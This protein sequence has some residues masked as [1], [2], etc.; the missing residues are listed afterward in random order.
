LS[1]SLKTNGLQI[2]SIS[3][4]I[5]ERST[6]HGWITVLFDRAPSLKPSVEQNLSN[7]SEIHV[8]LTK[9]A[10]DTL[11]AGFVEISAIGDD[12]CLYDGVYVL[13]MHV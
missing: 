4:S 10:E 6:R 1:N 13:E 2:I 9:V 7:G 11:P 12:I 5:L 3:P 8:T